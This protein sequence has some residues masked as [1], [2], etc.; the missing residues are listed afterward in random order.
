MWWDASDPQD[1][2]A[3]EQKRLKLKANIENF[4]N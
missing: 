4:Y 3:S 2:D 1:D